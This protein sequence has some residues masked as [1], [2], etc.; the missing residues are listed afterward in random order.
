MYRVLRNLLTPDETKELCTIL[1]KHTGS[2][3]DVQVPGSIAFYSPPCTNI[4][5]GLLRDRI[6]KECEK[7]LLPCYSYGRIY[8]NGNEL[9]KHRDRPACEYSVTINLYQTNEW[10]IFMD[11][12]PLNLM[13]GDGCVYEGCKV[14]HWRET[15]KGEEYVQ[16][17]LHYVDADGPYKSQA[18]DAENTGHRTDIR[19]KFTTLNLNLDR[20]W[21]SFCVFSKKECEQIID[22][23]SLAKRE[24][25]LV[26]EGTDDPK[27]RRSEVMWIPKTTDHEW[28][29]NRIM[30]VVAEANSTFFNVDI[31]E[32]IEDIQYTEYD[33]GYSGHYDWHIDVGGNKCSRKL[34]VSIQLSDPSTYEGGRLE[35]DRDEANDERGCAVV[36]P[37]YKRHRVTPVTRGKRCAL[38]AW[39]A[40]PPLR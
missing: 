37:S 38:V 21:R 24:K 22:D 30:T 2:S 27:I 18:F 34:S 31:T 8:K 39:I 23:F 14:E 35:F 20:W 12:E 13:P 32:L 7:K 1:K 17:F 9:K 40:G 11:G 29:Y 10:P 25:A 3:T 19:F 33:S 28:I 6:S 36:F 15:F 16:I 4:L 26:D 5:L